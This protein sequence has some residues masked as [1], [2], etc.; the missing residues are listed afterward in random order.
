M[1]A[2]GPPPM[3]S[4]RVPPLEPAQLAAQLGEVRVVDGR[5]REEFARRMSPDHRTWSL[6]PS[7]VC[8]W[9]GWFRPSK[10][11]CW[12]WIRAGRFPRLI[13]LGRIGLDR[14]QGALVGLEEWR[15]A[16]LP[17]ER[18]WVADPYNLAQALS[19]SGSLQVIDVRSREEWGRGTV[20]GSLTCYLPDLVDDLAG[21]FHADTETWVF[22]ETGFRAAAAASLLQRQGLRPVIVARGGA[23]EMAGALTGKGALTDGCR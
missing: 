13:Q 15:E 10:P 12:W 3:S 1:N 4:L 6:I 11:S 14:V 23:R 5:V 8:G 19:S 22:C 21:E 7:S 9:D 18:L 2:V 16:E 20:P 17:V